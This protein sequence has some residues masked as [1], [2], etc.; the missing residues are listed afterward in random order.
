MSCWWRLGRRSAVC[1]WPLLSWPPAL[2]YAIL[3]SLQGRLSPSHLVLPLTLPPP[4]P[5]T[6]TPCSN[7]ASL[8]ALQQVGKKLRVDPGGAP[9]SS[10]AP[11]AS[12]SAAPAAAPKAGAAKPDGAAAGDQQGKEGGGSAAAAGARPPA[13]AKDSSYWARGTG[14][15]FGAGSRQTWDP[16]QSE[17]AQRAHDEQRQEVLDALLAALVEDLGGEGEGGSSGSGGSG[18]ASMATPE[19]EARAAAAARAVA[20]SVLLPFARHHL[21]TATFTEMTGRAAFYSTLLRI[22]RALAGARAGARLLLGPAAPGVG[23]V[24]PAVREL[25]GSAR[26][27]STVIRKTVLPPGA[28]VPLTFPSATAAAG[29]ASG[30][31]P[32]AGVSGAAAGMSG[33]ALP[34]QPPNDG[35]AMTVTARQRAAA[36]AAVQEA[37]LGL[38]M[39]TLVTDTAERLDAFEAALSP[40]E[41]AALAAAAAAGGGGGSNGGAGTS[42]AAP[43]AEQQQQPQPAEE[44]AAAAPRRR[45]TRAAAAAEKAAAAER[46]GGGNGSGGSAGG[47]GNGAGGGGASTSGVPSEDYVTVMRPM[48]VRARAA[49]VEEQVA[50]QEASSTRAPGGTIDSFHLAPFFTSSLP[51]LGPPFRPNSLLPASPLNHVITSSP[52]SHQVDYHPAVATNHAYAAHARAEAAPLKTRAAR[53]AREIA[54]LDRVL[55]LTESTGACLWLPPACLPAL[56]ACAARVA[57]DACAAASD[58]SPNSHANNN[59]NTTPR[60]HPKGVFVRVD[61]ANAFL[62]RALIVGPEGTPYSGGCFLFDIYFPGTYP[63]VRGGF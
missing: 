47:G 30:A 3:S 50:G 60:N 19:A 36:D 7:E 12:T 53:V 62:W 11:G 15:G 2:C 8:E 43:G 58:L 39:A 31:G 41:R 29:A 33:A 27:Y 52:S 5:Y 13:A 25:A 35:P 22:A 4:T 59:N 45:M 10:G 28:E 54:G 63:Q 34:P 16:K 23:P 40:A 32:A 37:R 48:Q 9:G 24:A 26:L 55:P 1:G 17:A 61:E 57:A 51:P 6:E 14:Y 18:R 49:G 46:A 38:A 56:C 20:D 44:A 21:R 42:A